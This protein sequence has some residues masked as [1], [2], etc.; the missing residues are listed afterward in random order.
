M[1]IFDHLSTITFLYETNCFNQNDKLV[2]PLCL[3]GNGSQAIIT[4]KCTYK[5]GYLKRGTQANLHYLFIHFLI[6]SKYNHSITTLTPNKTKI[7]IIRHFLSNVYVPS[8]P[9]LYYR[10]IINLLSL[11]KWTKKEDKVT[12]QLIN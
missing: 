1:L 10:N 7:I 2:F 3:K 11:K 12:I 6:Q 4:S 5:K 8:I 9:K